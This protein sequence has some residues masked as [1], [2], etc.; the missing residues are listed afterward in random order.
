[1]FAYIF[2]EYFNRMWPNMNYVISNTDS[3]LELP[4]DTYAV[5]LGGGDVINPYFVEK[6]RKLLNNLYETDS[7]LHV[8][9]YAIGVGI[10]YLSQID[11]GSLDN[12][13]YII[14]RNKN[15]QDVL[16]DKYNNHVKWFPDLAFLLPKYTT[17][18]MI[19]PPFKEL[20]TTSNKKKIGVFLTRTMY[21]KNDPDSYDKIT[22]Q[23]AVFLTKLSQR[24]VHIPSKKKEFL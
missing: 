21:N 22:A 13:D 17:T 7:T 8:P 23:I 9:L 15:D 24:D 19:A 16:F 10:P 11:Q 2:G 14:H 4:L 6:V 20:I 12:F 5:V 3:L 1:V 18:N